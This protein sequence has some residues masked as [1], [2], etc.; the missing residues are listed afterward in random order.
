MQR[1]SL[2]IPFRRIPLWAA[3][4]ATALCLPAASASEH[5]RIEAA[6]GVYLQSV[7]GLASSRHASGPEAHA[8]VTRASRIV[9]GT[10]TTITQWPSVDTNQPMQ[11]DL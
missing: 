11:A 1:K 9:G 3:W 2:P 8:P 4:M 6:P 10:K 7:D 5:E